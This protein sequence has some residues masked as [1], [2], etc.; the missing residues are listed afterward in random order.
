MADADD[1]YELADFPD[2]EPPENPPAHP[3][4][5]QPKRADDEPAPEPQPAP[6]S[7]R[8]TNRAKID[9]DR[10]DKGALNDLSA[11][12]RQRLAEKAAGVHRKHLGEGVYV[13]LEPNGDIA[14]DK[15]C[16]AC[17][18][19][20]KGLQLDQ[21][22]PDCGV[23]VLRSVRGDHLKYSNAKWLSRIE[24][25]CTLVAGSLGL[26]LLGA[27]VMQ[28][29]GW[30]VQPATDQEVELQPGSLDE[31]ERVLAVLKMVVLLAVVLFRAGGIWLF[32]VAEPGVE[33]D[34]RAG[35]DRS[36]A[37]SCVLAAVGLMLIESLLVLA[38]GQTWIAQLPL[39]SS[40]A[41]LVAV[42]FL[43]RYATSLA[44]RVPDEPLAGQT[45]MV[46][47]GWAV[48]LPLVWFAQLT[49]FA[50]IDPIEGGPFLA[51]ALA[52]VC[53]A[54]GGLGVMVLAFWSLILLLTYRARVLQAV[55][56]SKSI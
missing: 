35:L 26:L 42:V 36:V 31:G 29:V 38:M 39:L 13:A 9:R 34:K 23:L 8:Q 47:L 25:G 16:V 43:C 27:L 14:E 32:T 28:V 40:V 33:A 41:G 5:D 22:C 54:V 4:R 24:L 7:P 37:R 48:A 56:R 12:D 3:F 52:G 11:E 30:I 51:T 10:Y 15:P 44:M 45:K 1:P 21:V 2:D 50:L 18:R 17:S 19:N 20:L 49:R 6:A 46:M 55:E 53:Q